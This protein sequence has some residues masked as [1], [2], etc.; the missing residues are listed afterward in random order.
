MSLLNE[1]LQ[2]KDNEP[3]NGCKYFIF[4]KKDLPFCQI[5]DK[6]LLPDFLPTKC[7]LREE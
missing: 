7:E 2:A 6:I 3:C 5:K 4:P 1:I